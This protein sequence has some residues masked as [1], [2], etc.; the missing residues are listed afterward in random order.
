[1]VF[2]KTTQLC[3]YSMK[4]VCTYMSMAV[5]QQKFICKNRWQARFGL[6]A[7]VCQPLVQ[8][9]SEDLFSRLTLSAQ[10]QSTNQT[11]TEWNLF[12]MSSS[13]TFLKGQHDLYH[14]ILTFPQTKPSSFT[15]LKYIIKNSSKITEQLK[16]R[17]WNKREVKILMPLCRAKLSFIITSVDFHPHHV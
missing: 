11:R 14:L 2:V 1:M 4:A 5:F 12:D 8:V 10:S 13:Y 9:I 3:S 17:H 16:L 6:Q 7:I 15:A